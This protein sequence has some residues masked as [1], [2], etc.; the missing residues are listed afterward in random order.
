MNE[1]KRKY[2]IGV[3]VHIKSLGVVFFEEDGMK[4]SISHFLKGNWN[5]RFKILF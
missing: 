5:F 2:I 1:K 4:F 3:Y